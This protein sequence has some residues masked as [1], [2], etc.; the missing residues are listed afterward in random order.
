MCQTIRMTVLAM[1]FLL[2]TAVFLRAA[3][4]PAGRAQLD[5]HGNGWRYQFVSGSSD[6]PNGAWT[7]A[8]SLSFNLSAGKNAV[9]LERTVAVPADWQG[10][11]V[12]LHLD[13]LAFAAKV[14]VNGADAGELLAYG[15][16]L[17]L[18]GLLHFGQDN[19]LRL[20]FPRGAEGIK[21]LD[22]VTQAMVNGLKGRYDNILS[23]VGVQPGENPF[24]LECRPAEL[25]VTDVW[26]RTST[27][28]FTSIAPEVTIRTTKPV[29]GIT[30]RLRIIDTG[31]GAVAREADY[32]LPPLDAGESLHHLSLDASGLK[33]WD[34]HQPNLY[35]GQVLLLD[36]AGHE[37][38]RSTPERFGIR[39]FW[40]QGKD[41]YLNNHRVY[42]I[43]DVTYDKW[44]S[45]EEMFKAGVTLT[46]SENCALT[47]YSMDNP[48]GTITP[49]DEHGIGCMVPGLI[50]TTLFSGFADLKDPTALNDYRTWLEHHLRRLRNHPSVLYYGLGACVGGNQIDFSPTLLG[51]FSQQHLAI[52]LADGRLSAA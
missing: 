16:E 17:E 41:L 11:R 19:T 20:L 36:A 43:L 22:R 28:G 27:R 33:L 23:S 35:W 40:A 5:L 26:Y 14:V 21:S 9:W 30:A 10:Q 6:A 29:A 45:L 52:R 8:T 24:Y 2:G 47:S 46:E 18:T 42:F 34:I 44:P 25:A 32:P 49:C 4:P 39:E 31:S 37:L 38:D 7:P 50:A 51:F 13:Y 15:G 3:K 12:V 48:N 1:V